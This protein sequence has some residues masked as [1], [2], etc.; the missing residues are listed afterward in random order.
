MAPSLTGLSS[1]KF[2][3]KNTAR[4]I[5]ATKKGIAF[6]QNPSTSQHDIA[7]VQ[8]ASTT[9]TVGQAVDLMEELY[10]Y[11][12]RRSRGIILRLLRRGYIGLNDRQAE[13]SRVF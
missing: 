8:F 3:D 2:I 11:T 5:H 1:T 10:E 4:T 12:G 13:S 7:I 9:P 6:A